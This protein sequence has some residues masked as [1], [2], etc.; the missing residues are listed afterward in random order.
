MPPLPGS[1]EARGKVVPFHD[2]AH[3]LMG[4]TEKCAGDLAEIT[5]GLRKP[6]AVQR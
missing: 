6:V 2:A 1:T 5:T 3:P 4:S